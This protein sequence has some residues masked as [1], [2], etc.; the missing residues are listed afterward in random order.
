MQLR[1]QCCRKSLQWDQECNRIVTT[2]FI[3]HGEQRALGG[4]WELIF[5][6]ER[7]TALTERV[8]KCNFIS[9]FLWYSVKHE[10]YMTRLEIK[11]P[12]N[13]IF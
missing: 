1:L 8:M 12:K 7:K 9:S 13:S 11:Q 2:L 10:Y 5:Y 4:Q 3:G 6:L